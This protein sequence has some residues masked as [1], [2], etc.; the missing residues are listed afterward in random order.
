[1]LLHNL[2]TFDCVEIILRHYRFI[3]D[4]FGLVVLENES[5]LGSSCR[6]GGK[7]DFAASFFS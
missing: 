4:M 6:V 2:L 3:V 7:K 5:L 1:M